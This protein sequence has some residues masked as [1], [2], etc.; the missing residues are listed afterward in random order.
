MSTPHSCAR[1]LLGL[2]TQLTGKQAPHVSEQAKQLVDRLGK[3]F[4]R[5]DSWARPC[6]SFVLPG[7]GYWLDD[8]RIQEFRASTYEDLVRATPKPMPVYI[9]GNPYCP[10]QGQ[11]RFHKQKQ[12]YHL[13]RKVAVSFDGEIFRATDEEILAALAKHEGAPATDVATYIEAVKEVRRRHAAKEAHKSDCSGNPS[14]KKRHRVD[15]AT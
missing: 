11:S 12:G 15:G 4:F 13:C 6:A 14:D 3:G 7:E 9:K 8:N 2:S 5:Q 1:C 10:M